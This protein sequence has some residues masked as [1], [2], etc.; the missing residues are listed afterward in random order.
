MTVQK[1]VQEKFGKLRGIIDQRQKELIAH[2][3]AKE[4]EKLVEIQNAS[5]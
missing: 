3:K 4:E 2:V 5:R 1:E